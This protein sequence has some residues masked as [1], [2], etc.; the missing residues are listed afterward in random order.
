MR[1][2]ASNLACRR[3]GRDVFAD[4]SFSVGPG[5]ALAIRG[6]NGAGKSSLLRMVVGLV[7]I[8][9]GRLAL[10]GGDPEL[11]IAEQA[12]YLGHQDAFKPSLLVRENLQFW[13][14][15]LGAEAAELSEPLAA[16]GLDTLVDR[17]PPRGR[18]ADLAA[19]RAGQYARYRGAAKPGRIHGGAPR[20]RRRHAGRNPWRARAPRR[21]RTLARSS[22][23]PPWGRK[24]RGGWGGSARTS[25]P[26]SGLAAPAPSPSAQRGEVEP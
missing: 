10:E 5:E 14:H 4:V 17:P 23:L 7:R 22:S 24:L 8:T 11:T 1:L 6:R 21:A 2:T 18:A 20:P 12:H 19:R 15:F 25:T 16:V 26:A 9:G 3:G 13:T